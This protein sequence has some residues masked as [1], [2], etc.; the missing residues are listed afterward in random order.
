M[1]IRVW[2]THP[3]A[4]GSTLG[5]KEPVVDHPSFGGKAVEVLDI[6]PGMAGTKRYTVLAPVEGRMTAC[7]FL[8][9]APHPEITG[10]WFRTIRERP[11]VAPTLTDLARGLMSTED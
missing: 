1:K 7:S 11:L 5:P 3:G 6:E 9:R 8:D 10:A 2:E 4:P